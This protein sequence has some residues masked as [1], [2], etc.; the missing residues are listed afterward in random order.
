MTTTNSLYHFPLRVLVINE[1]AYS[2]RW[3]LSEHALMEHQK[4]KDKSIT[5]R[6][7]SFSDPDAD[8]EAA[9]HALNPPWKMRL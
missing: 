6:R 7:T 5:L 3:P 2:D 4:H 8:A 1:E 9:V